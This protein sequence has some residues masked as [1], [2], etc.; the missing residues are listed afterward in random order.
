MNQ[1]PLSPLLSASAGKSRARPLLK[2]LAYRELKQLIQSGTIPA[3][4]FLSE[5]QL[6]ERLGM[7]KTPIRSA[8]ERLEADGLVV[9]SP[10][11]GIVVREVSLREIKELFDVR[12]A[13]EPFVVRRLADCLMPEPAEALRQNLKEQASAVKKGDA[14]AAGQLDIR[15]HLLLAEGLDNREI[16]Q[17]LDR[18]LAR[19]SRE[20]LRINRFAPGRLSSSYQEHAAIFRAV[21]DN[22][23]EQA[24]ER[25]VVHLRFGRQYL[26]SN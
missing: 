6:V 26:V 25:M 11:Q 24:A 22:Q 18:A 23:P 5:R 21:L 8:L 13:I 12:L 4:T 2:E 1:A 3:G 16:V 17:W 19:L 10:Q 9:V 14:T 20:I 7:S 15:F